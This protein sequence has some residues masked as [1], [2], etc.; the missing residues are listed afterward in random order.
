M[1]NVAPIARQFYHFVLLVVGHE[2][3]A[4]RAVRLNH[5][6]THC[7][8]QTLKEVPAGLSTDLL[9][10]NSPSVLHTFGRHGT[11]E[12]AY[13]KVHNDPGKVRKEDDQVERDKDEGRLRGSV[14]FFHLQ[15]H[16]QVSDPQQQQQVTVVEEGDE[17]EDRED[18]KTLE[19]PDQDARS[20]PSSS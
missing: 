5:K 17:G 16:I 18:A 19:E 12:H 6:V 14:S 2:A 11:E 10:R 9:T 1:E 13:T 15:I 20:K 8:C 4:A 3:D 7:I